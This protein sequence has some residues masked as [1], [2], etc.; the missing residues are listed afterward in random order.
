VRRTVASPRGQARVAG[1]RFLASGGTF[2]HPDGFRPRRGVPSWVEE[3]TTRLGVVAGGNTVSD[4]RSEPGP[5][6]ALVDAAL[7]AANP[8]GEFP[9]DLR[10]SIG[11]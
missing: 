5:P 8:A 9:V 2:A 10:G 11:E 7:P 3:R 1:R 4:G 6:S